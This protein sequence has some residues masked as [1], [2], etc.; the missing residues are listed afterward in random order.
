M[1][2]QF[3]GPVTVAGFRCWQKCHGD[4]RLYVVFMAKPAIG[5]APY[6]CVVDDYGTLQPTANWPSYGR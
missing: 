1:K 6:L 3:L 4:I 5:P 2:A